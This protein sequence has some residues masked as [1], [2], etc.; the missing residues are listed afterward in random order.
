MEERITDLARRREQALVPG[1]V[2]RRGE[3]GARERVERLV[4]KGSFTET[5][6][7]V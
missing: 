7:F 3:F 2:R 1:G 4:D 5:G 6:L